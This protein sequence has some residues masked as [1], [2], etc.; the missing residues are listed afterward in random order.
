[1][2]TVTAHKLRWGI[3]GAANIARKNWKAIQLTGNST[4]T[5]VASRDVERSRQFIADCQR[6]APMDAVPR[7]FASYE[8]LLASDTVD[9]VYVPLPT[10]LRKPLILRAAAAGKHVLCEKPCATSV[11]DLREMI[12]A[13]RK[14]RVQF[15][16]GVMFMHSRRLEALRQVLEDPAE[17]GEVRRLTSAFTFYEPPAWFDTNIR[18]HSEL[19]PTGCLGDLG[20]Y[21]I[22]FALW[23]KRWE[24]PRQVTGRLLAQHHRVDS[25]TGVP[26]A[27]SGELHFDDKV[28]CAFYCS[29]VAET[30]Q[31][32]RIAGTHGI[33][34]VPDFVLPLAGDKVGFTVHHPRFQ[35]TGCDFRM[36]EQIRRI[37]VDEHSHG[38]PSAQEARLFGAFA[39]QV[40]T[41]ELNQAWPDAAMKTQITMEACLVSSANGGTAVAVL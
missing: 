38:H 11:A 7:A 4:V 27:F 13:C 37:T 6:E 20:W 34:V 16:D 2:S 17:I 18:T 15:S 30:E 24:L 5:A 23:L 14:N 3:L 40:F 26:T 36:T 8:E 31:W 29:F 39:K 28:S 32:V 35:V 22:R 41:G 25:P 12:D 10:G 1:M 19:E 21:C 9:A 33:L